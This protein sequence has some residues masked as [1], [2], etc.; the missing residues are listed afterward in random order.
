[1]KSSITRNGLT[2]RVVAGTHNVFLAFDLEEALRPGCL[3]FALERTDLGAAP[4]AAAAPGAPRWLPNMLSFNLPDGPAA[5][6][7]AQTPP[8]PGPAHLHGSDQEPLQKFRWGDYQVQPNHRYRYR[9]VPRY[10]QAGQLTNRDGS[11]LGPA[12]GVSV[13][14]TTEDPKNP[15]FLSA[16]FFNRAAAASEAFNRE[17]PDVKDVSDASPEADKARAWLSNGLEEALLAFLAQAT[18]D[19]FALHAAVYEFQKPSLLAGLKAA[20]GRGVPVEVA[21][22]A[23]QKN[24]KEAATDKTKAANEAAIQAAGLDQNLPNLKLHPRQA[25]PQGAIMHNKFV[26]L[27]KKDGTGQYKAFRVWTGST[28]WTDG[29]IYGQLNVGHAFEDPTAADQYEQYFQ[30]L[31]A[32]TLAHDMKNEVAHITPVS[33]HLPGGQQIIPIFSPQDNDA[34]LRLY[35]D[36]CTNAKCLLVS[37]PFALSPFILTSLKADTPDVVRLLLLDKPGS[38]GKP[39]DIQ[40]IEKQADNLISVATTI[41]SPLNDYQS[42]LLEGR[43]GFHHAGIHIH[44]KIIVADPFGADPIVVTGSANFSNNSTQVNDSNTLI[45]RGNT[46]VADIYTTEFMRMFEHYHFRVAQKKASATKPLG[47]TNDDSWSEAYYEKGSS[48]ERARRQFAGTH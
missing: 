12:D 17:F 19:S 14:V 13:E 5:G 18:D 3:G 48:S 27:L 43:E 35:A 25:D 15:S 16:V 24:A 4:D 1:M 32:D 38:L 40:A 10:G 6:A 28:N 23:R 47:L 41:D 36:I 39:A 22:H 45:V 37:A 33:L 21:Y 7:P 2:L 11:P 29:G 26:V 44:S 8:A 46:A 31:A 42:R 30:L 20:A 34:M 9:L